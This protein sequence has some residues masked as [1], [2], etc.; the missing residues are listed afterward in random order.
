MKRPVYLLGLLLAGIVGAQGSIGAGGSNALFISG[1][2]AQTPDGETPAN[3][4]VC[5]ELL[6]ATPGLYG[7]C[8]AYCEAQDC[9][10]FDMAK[11]AQC[12]AAN[13]RIL[14]NYNTKKQA[15]DPDMPCVQPVCPCFTP[16]DLAL[17]DTPYVS[18]A[19]TQGFNDPFSISNFAF[20]FS[21]PLEGAQV[22]FLG[23][24]GSGN[25]F[26]AHQR[27]EGPL[28]RFD[29]TDPE[30]TAVCNQLILDHIQANIDQCLAV[31]P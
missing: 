7:L 11:A 13:P 17:I 9:D 14:D 10:D 2:A 18:C 8:V 12:K 23:E 6:G 4:G 31:F 20:S 26:F 27:P 15:G 1:V 28:I 3:E 16:E 24:D 29:D 30:V 5:D 21:K 19:S 25:C 22:A